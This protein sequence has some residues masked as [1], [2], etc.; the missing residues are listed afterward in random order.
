MTKASCEDN[1]IVPNGGS[2][3]G[4]KAYSGLDKMARVNAQ[5]LPQE[6]MMLE[7]DRHSYPS[8]PQRLHKGSTP[9]GGN[10]GGHL[11]SS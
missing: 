2:S 6:P 7:C 4:V 10:G 9:T 8:A 5:L 11:H 1:N 3:Q